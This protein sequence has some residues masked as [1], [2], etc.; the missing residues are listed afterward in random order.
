VSSV[1]PA[2]LLIVLLGSGCAGA[3]VRVESRAPPEAARGLVLVVDGA[4]GHQIAA[5]TIS[6]TVDEQR[7]PLHVRSFDWAHGT[8][9]GIADE[10]DQDHSRCSAA[11]LAEEVALY[12]K[13]YPR[14]PI[15]LVAYSAGASV[16]LRAAEQLPAGSVERIVLLAPAVSVDYDLRPAL[17]CSRL[18]IDSFRSERDTFY[19]GVG[20]GLL[21]TSDGRRGEAAG[22][23]GFRPVVDSPADAA[24]YAKLREH[25]WDPCVEWTGHKGEHNG[26]YHTRYF[27]AYVLPLLL[28][29]K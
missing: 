17:A 24:L 2:C 15:Y 13:Q 29:E 27:A 3:S 5:R 9:L 11:R 25:P 12:R 1:R 16:A 4:G 14:L 18:G 26:G 20:T 8:G 6:A 21:G 19:L 23:Y 22:R 10:V 7:L 28:P